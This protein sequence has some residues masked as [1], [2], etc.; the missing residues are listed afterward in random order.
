[1]HAIAEVMKK[2]EPPLPVDSLIPPLNK[3]ME[4]F[5]DQKTPFKPTGVIIVDNPFLKMAK[6]GESLP[7]LLL[8]LPKLKSSVGKQT[9]VAAGNAS[10]YVNVG[11]Y[12]INYH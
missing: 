9:Q 12:P 2:F 6:S 10:I 4:G 11:Y 5:D 7:T 3:T 1:M 8:S